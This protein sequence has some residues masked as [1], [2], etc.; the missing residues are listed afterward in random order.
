MASFRGAIDMS[1]YAAIFLISSIAG[2]AL[3]GGLAAACFTKAF[4]IVFLGEP[5]SKAAQNAHESSPWMTIPMMLLAIACIVI[6]LMGPFVIQVMSPVLGTI[7]GNPHI[8]EIQTASNYLEY[9]TIGSVIFIILLVVFAGLRHLLLS[10]R[11][12]GKAGTWDCGYAAPTVRMQ[13]TASSFAQPAIELF[14][15]FLRTKKHITI[16]D[17]YFPSASHFETHTPD[18]GRENIYNPIFKAIG[19]FFLRMKVV[20]EGRIHIYVLYVVA[21]LLVLLFWNMR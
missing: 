19:S 6:G 11:T 7:L 10:G 1:P 18:I 2:L 13:Y 21:A 16:P 3:I 4:G 14:Q 9:V 12:V 8:G 17:T 5:R 15:F 20:Q